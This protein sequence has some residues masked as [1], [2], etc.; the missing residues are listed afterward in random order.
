MALMIG[1]VV[2][3]MD[4]DDLRK[5]R[6]CDVK[7]DNVTLKYD[8]HGRKLR[9]MPEV[10]GNATSLD[11]SENE[12]E[13]LTMDS[14]KGLRKLKNL[15]LSWMNTKN[16]HSKVNIAEGV[17]S[18]LT[19]LKKLNLS[20]LRLLEIPAHLPKSL[21]ELRL[22]QNH[23]FA[24]SPRNFLQLPNLTHIYLSKNCYYW[25]PCLVHF[26]I[27]NGTFS[28]LNK[29]EHLS[30]SYNNLTHVPRN[31]PDSLVTLELA[32]NMISFIGEDDFKDLPKLKTLK[33]QGNCPRCYNAPYPCI[34]CAN[35]S[36]NI[37]ERAFDHLTN[38]TLLH[39]AGNSISSIKKSWFENISHL[40]ELYLSYNFLTRQIQEDGAFL[41]NL[42]FLKKLDLSYNYG[43]REYPETVHLAPNFANLSGLVTLHIQGLVFKKIRNDSL[44]PLYGLQNL[45]TLDIGIN[46]IVNVNPDIFKKFQK[47]KMLYLSENRLYP[48][49]ES[50]VGKQDNSIEPPR[51]KLPFLTGSLSRNKKDPYRPIQNLVK[52]ECYAAGHVLDLSR[53]NL[54]FLSPEQFQGYENISCLN[55]SRNGF[56]AALNGTE[57]ASM[58]NLKYL[59]LSYNKIDLAYD[60]AFEELKDL[61]VLDLSFN[62]HYFTVRGVT[63]NL[64]F[65]K[66]LP[67][68]RVLNMSSN[69]IFTLTTKYMCSDTLTELQ[70]QSNQLGR[71]WK[72]EKYRKIFWN[73]TNLTHLDISDN[74]IK[75][76]PTEVYRFLPVTIKSFR[77]NNNGLMNLN[78]T[79]MRTF[80]QLEE[81]FLGCNQLMYVSKEIIQNVP[82]LHHL[83]LSHNRI[84]QLETNFLQNAV[85]LKKLDLSY[86]KLSTINQST[87]PNKSESHLEIL[88]LHKNPY[89]CTCEIFD[90]VIWIFQNDVKIPHLFSLVQCSVPEVTKGTLMIEFD[91]SECIDDD[92][93]FKIYIS[94]TFLIVL[95]T[96]VA[97][98]MH[99]FYWDYSYLF[100]YMKAKLKGY[101][102]LSSGDNV[103]DAFVTYDTKDPQVSDWVLSHLRV[104]LEE[105]GDGFLPVCL[106][107]RDWLPGCPV[108]DSLTQ[109]IRQS[110]KTVFVLTHSYVNSGSFKMAMYLAHQRLLDESEDVIVL[111]LLEPVLQNS[112]FL[113]L[114]R[115]L[116]S[117]SVIEWPR[118]PAAEPWFWQCLRNAIRL[119]NKIMYSNIYSRYF[120]IRKRPREKER[121]I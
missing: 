47:V 112:H 105:Q 121:T 4:L 66:N 2:C 99:M 19:E 106:E 18:N 96:F 60:Y 94:S 23:I 86:N 16:L 89:R 48:V 25:N 76:L 3:R 91:I 104:Q 102:H 81:L 114:R 83:D 71:L 33:I 119:E 120:T 73:L 43:L 27:D 87:F 65:L 97:T 78:W 51:F 92:L 82:S 54:F 10:S 57:F 11:V 50:I 21:K 7:K 59:D 111:L 118:T 6:L 45:S 37:H 35:V 13:N 116:C 95:V 1:L 26:Q 5:S 17:F 38:L 61:E 41:N 113:R 49:T 93:A 69:S 75:N 103:Y 67:K 100:Y 15:N 36:I 22:D 117:H 90:F 14:L 44:T 115:R 63:H 29:L 20:G 80:T 70:F 79:L 84:S 9:Q 8:C 110:R 12:I 77:L 107:E 72:D 58:P 62:P 74:R 42:S 85:H 34:P 32:S 108:L 30:L 31:L 39:L 88:W 28:S 52:P 101:Q 53:N 40:R 56:A 46:F 68:L 55:L 98:L 109:S 24:L 64:K